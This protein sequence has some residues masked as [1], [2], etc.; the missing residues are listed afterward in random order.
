MA[1]PVVHFEIRSADPDAARTFFGQV[2]DWKFSP[3]AIPGYTYVEHGLDAGPFAGAVISA[4]RPPRV[5]HRHGELWR[6]GSGRPK[7][8]AQLTE[9]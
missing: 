5:W 9:G 4:R 1:N 8:R 3:G 2:L 6:I 7:R